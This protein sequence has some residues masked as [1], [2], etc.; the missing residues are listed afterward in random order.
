MG[1]V[2]QSLD[3]GLGGVVGGDS[4]VGDLVGQTVEQVVHATVNVDHEVV[5][6]VQGA[7][8]TDGCAVH[9]SRGGLDHNVLSFVRVSASTRWLQLSL[10]SLGQQSHVR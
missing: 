6:R 2:V 8:N 4:H 7:L 3:T 5:Q 10:Q 1:T 9:N